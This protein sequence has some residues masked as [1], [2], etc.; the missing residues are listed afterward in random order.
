MEIYNWFAITAKKWQ[1]KIGNYMPCLTGCNWI[2]YHQLQSCVT[3]LLQCYYTIELFLKAF[4][5]MCAAKCFLI[6]GLGGCKARTL[7][8]YIYLCECMHI[9]RWDVVIYILA[10]AYYEMHETVCSNAFI[11]WFI[12]PLWLLLSESLI[13]TLF[14]SS[15]M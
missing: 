7:D 15:N 1:A 12:M 8:C 14:A 9:C 13:S 10:L 6:D 4:I 3:D 5:Y 2:S 11:V